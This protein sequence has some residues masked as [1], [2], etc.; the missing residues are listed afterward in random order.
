M[1]FAFFA[2][3]RLL[4]FDLAGEPFH[5]DLYVAFDAEQRAPA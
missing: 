5:P 4:F 3:A 2:F 1:R